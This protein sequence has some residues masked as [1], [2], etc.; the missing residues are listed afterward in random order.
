MSRDYFISMNDSCFSLVSSCGRGKGS[1]CDASG[2]SAPL[3]CQHSHSNGSDCVLLK[4]ALTNAPVLVPEPCSPPP[5]LRLLRH[6]TGTRT[7]QCMALRTFQHHLPR[8]DC[9]RLF[10]QACSNDIFAASMQPICSVRVCPAVHAWGRDCRTI[11]FILDSD[12]ISK[13]AQ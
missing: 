5:S 4:D 12:L 13:E 6:G 2:N 8:S 1:V 10:L 9:D 7:S 11:V 3:F